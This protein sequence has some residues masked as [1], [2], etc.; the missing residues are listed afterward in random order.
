MGHGLHDLRWLHGH[1]QRGTGTENPKLL[2]SWGASGVPCRNTE[3][4]FRKV[5]DGGFGAR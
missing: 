4:N 2:L 5:P 3:G 1:M